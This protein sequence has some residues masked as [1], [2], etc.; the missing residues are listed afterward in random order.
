MHVCNWE[1][2]SENGHTIERPERTEIIKTQSHK[3]ECGRTKTSSI[4][5]TICKIVKGEKMAV[6]GG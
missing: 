5:E 4:Q 2:T 6:K 3:C 1:L